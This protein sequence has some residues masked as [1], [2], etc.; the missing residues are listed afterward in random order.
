MQLTYVVFNERTEAFL[1]LNVVRVSAADT[2]AG[3]LRR[4]KIDC[5]EGLWLSP[6]LGV[7]TLR[8]L[9]PIDVICLDAGQRVIGLIEH[10]K[11]LSV[12]LILPETASLLELPAHTIY[13]S[14]T[15]VGDRVVTCFPRDLKRMLSKKE[16]ADP[17]K[18]FEAKAASLS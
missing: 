9:F 14:Q 16:C 3:L 5:G 10:L 2:N 6:A 12:G 15:R 7:H 8:M 1:A 17:S 4:F 18:S 13:T 11:P